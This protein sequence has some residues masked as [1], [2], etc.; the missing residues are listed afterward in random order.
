MVFI[1]GF[2]NQMVFSEETNK[3]ERFCRSV[4]IEYIQHSYQSG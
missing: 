1:C 4:L 3:Q 2:M